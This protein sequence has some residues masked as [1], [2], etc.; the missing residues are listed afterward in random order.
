MN[1]DNQNLIDDCIND[2]NNVKKY[3][4]ANALSSICQYLISYAVVRSCGTI[5]VVVK[6][7]IFDYLSTGATQETI[8][9]LEKQI[10]DS[11]WNPSCGK[12]QKLLDMINPS[13]SQEFQA[14]T[15]GTKEKT[16]LSSLVNLRN[17][18]AHG[19]KVTSSIDNVIDYFEGSC[20][21]VN[22][23]ADIVK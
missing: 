14:F 20:T 19:N 15:N 8:N 23:L 17:D 11:S 12:I 10:L 2:L 6:N 1:G 7:I 3:I 5:E 4:A 22:F 21:I 9:F 16:D 18:F 13:W